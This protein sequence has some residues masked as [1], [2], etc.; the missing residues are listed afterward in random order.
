MLNFCMMKK[1]IFVSS[2]E[3]NH[4]YDKLLYDNNTIYFSK[5]YY[6]K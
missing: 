5:R 4:S 3:A 1:Y 6:K 2:T